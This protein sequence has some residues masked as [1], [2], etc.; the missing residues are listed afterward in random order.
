MCMSNSIPKNV[1]KIIIIHVLEIF[2]I[3]KSLLGIIFL[4]K[5]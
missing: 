4:K 1:E 2:E 5:L 3:F